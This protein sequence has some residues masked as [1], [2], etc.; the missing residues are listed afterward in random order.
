MQ[1]F[2]LQ[3]SLTRASL[4][5]TAAEQLMLRQ[6]ADA[7]PA[8]IELDEEAVPQNPSFGT[9]QVE[10][11]EV[12]GTVVGNGLLAV[13]IS[14]LEFSKVFLVPVT[15]GMSPVFSA[16]AIADYL[17]ADE[18]FDNFAEMSVIATS[19]LSMMVL[20][21]ADNDPSMN[22]NVGGPGTSVTGVTA[23]PVSTNEV[24]G[25]AGSQGTPGEPGQLADNGTRTWVC[26]VDIGN[27]SQPRT[28]WKEVLRDD[29]GN[30][31]GLVQNTVGAG[32]SLALR[33]ADQFDALQELTLSG[34]ATNELINIEPVV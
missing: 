19:T 33:N 30:N 3:P 10:T 20:A 17:N 23:D 32:R 11:L 5:L 22:I 29:A 8:C 21:E 12:L 1:H 9:Q 24:E 18:E 34:T 14:S 15:D 27:T 16:I 31:F 2:F 7:V 13:V 28:I 25:V 6:N 26:I 4:G